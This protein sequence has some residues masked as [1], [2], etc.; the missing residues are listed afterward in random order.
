MYKINKLKGTIDIY[1]DKYYIFNYIINK[2]K[3]IL[4]FYGYLPIKTPSVE[5]TKILKYLNINLSKKIIYNFN[6]NKFL[7]Y[8]LT[9]PLIRFINN[10]Y[11]NLIFPFKRYQIQRVWRGEK[12]QYNRYREFYQFDIDVISFKYNKKYYIELELLTICEKIFYKLKLKAIL[13]IN[14]KKILYDLCN[15]LNIK[16]N[17]INK[18]IIILDKINKIKLNNIINYIKSN[19]I[20]DKKNYKKFIF[21]YKINLI[22][23]NKKKILLLYKIFNRYNINIKNLNYIK[24]IYNKLLNYNFK[25]LNLNI[26]FLL[27]RG[28]NYYSNIIFEIKTNGYNNIS[29]LGGGSYNNYFKINNKNTYYIGMSIGIYRLLNYF[30]D[31]LKNINIKI[32]KIKIL[33]INLNLEYY[34]Y[35][36]YL[37]LFNNK[38]I[39]E[40]YPHFVKIKKQIKYAIKKKINILIF[41]GNKEIKNNIIKVKDLKRGEEYIFL[42]K[43][44]FIKFLENYKL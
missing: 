2:I 44:N 33:F 43:K 27:S 35:Y 18:F 31:E 26:N 24:F 22:K 29:L 17:K 20:I 14:N 12:P 3:I 40:I 11:N 16:K 28:L 6:K 41:I 37:N 21:L 30:L 32:K 10:N 39:V 25:N 4:K 23:N 42:K 8:D 13:E 19:K 15:L 7:I 9:I 38:Y 1:N 36:K 34:I 5:N